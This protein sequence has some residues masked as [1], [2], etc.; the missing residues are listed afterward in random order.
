MWSDHAFCCRCLF[1]VIA[2]MN[3]TVSTSPVLP[4]V[5]AGMANINIV[6]CSNIAVGCALSL[7]VSP[8]Y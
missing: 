3:K 7:P 1:R 4:Y 2:T 6:Y 5:V 8:R